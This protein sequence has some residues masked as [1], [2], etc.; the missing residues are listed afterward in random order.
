MTREY[1]IQYGSAAF[2]GRFAAGVAFARG[3]R[4]VVES[5]RGVEL[6][7]VLCEPHEQL[8]R[9]VAPTTDGR[10]L[11]PATSEDEV[12]QLATTDRASDLLD[13]ANADIAAG[14]LPALVLDC[15]VLLDSSAAILHVT[16]WGELDLSPL[17]DRWSAAFGRPVR[18][19]DLTAMPVAAEPATGCGKDGC[20][21]GGGGCSSCGTG[22]CGTGGGCSR[23]K[24]KSGAELTAYFRDL[25]EKMEAKVVGRRGLV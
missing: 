20:G 23:G 11:R 18:L 7:T 15:E 21:S 5:P 16:T 3:S 9:A 19:H 25:R 17:L 24:V 10:V 4:A 14:E 1:L 22:N 13:A 2:V 6:G 8:R 12:E